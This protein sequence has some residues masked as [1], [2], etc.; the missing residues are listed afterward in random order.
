V[1]G[2]GVDINKLRAK[3]RMPRKSLISKMIRRQP[4]S[5]RIAGSG[6]GFRSGVATHSLKPFQTRDFHTNVEIMA[7][8]RAGWNS[9][10]AWSEST[11]ETALHA[12]ADAHDRSD[13][14]NGPEGSQ[15]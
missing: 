6:T 9:T 1:Q 15:Q 8:T 12:C 3:S 13:K 7:C 5:A 11:Q 14:S 2:F 4:A 10:Q